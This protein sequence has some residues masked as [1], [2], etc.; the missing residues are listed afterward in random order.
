MN[1]II[2]NSNKLII[3]LSSVLSLL[4]FFTFMQS[5]STAYAME[6]DGDEYDVVF[7][8]NIEKLAKENY[9]GEINLEA[10][11]ELIYDIN[12]DTLGYVYNFTINNENGYA[13][14]IN[15]IGIFE[16]VELFFNSKNPY[17]NIQNEQRVY[18][19][20]MTYLYYIDTSY[21][22]INNNEIKLAID[23][24]DIF[25][26]VAYF[27][28]NVSFTPSSENIYYTSKVESRHQLSKIHPYLVEVDFLRNECAVIAGANLIQYWDRYKSNLIPNYSPGRELGTAYIYSGSSTTTNNVI[29]ELYNNMGTNNPNLGTTIT[30]FKNGLT[31][32]ANKKGYSINF[33]SCMQNNSFNYNMAKEKLIQ[34]QPVAL[35]LDKYHLAT[36]TNETGYDHIDYLIDTS[37]HTMV[38]FGYKEIVYTLSNGTNRIDKY[39]EI[40]TAS[41]VRSKGYLNVNYHNQIDQAYGVSI[42]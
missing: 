6:L 24:L 21:Y 5:I 18:V 20:N 7:L 31:T 34:G 32:Y 27:S 23:D 42:A 1:K 13:I 26:E 30:Q 11:K 12:L 25:M 40:A 38:G 3:L 15:S 33:D 28:N 36:M 29:S 19:D 4:C 14:A 16:I 22:F 39:I 2:Q 41:S 35:F 9:E 8:E 17:E 37:T 10:T